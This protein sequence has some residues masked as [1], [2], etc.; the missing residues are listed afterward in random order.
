MTLR[1]RLTAES[2]LGKPVSFPRED[3]GGWILVI[4]LMYQLIREKGY[5]IS[6]KQIKRTALKICLEGS[7]SWP[8]ELI[9]SRVSTLM[10]GVNWIFG[11]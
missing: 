11:H 2:K 4:E 6:R 7:I 1:S 8:S 10:A 5:E 9:T 3:I